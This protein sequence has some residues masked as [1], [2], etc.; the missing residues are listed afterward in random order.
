M[1]YLNS[2][3]WRYAAKRMNGGKLSQTQL[4]NILEATRLSASSFGLQPY[5]ILVIENPEVRAKLVPAAWNQP[6]LT[7]CSHLLVFC[8]WADVTEAQVTAY[9]EDTAQIRGID[10]AVL[11]DFKGMIL[12]ALANR[13]A[14]EKS[15][16]AA[17]QCYIA[18]G[19]TLIAAALENVDATPMEG[20]L[21][22]Q[23]DEILGLAAQG[24][25]SVLL[26][27]LGFRAAEGDYLAGAKKV[28]RA[29]SKLFKFI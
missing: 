29:K 18:L 1:S 4:D 19:S 11:N 20:F 10:V 28:R 22:A 3:N 27:P 5:T 14:A 25:R 15:E 21:P 13:T 17:K 26:C 12:G 2:L 8:A 7:E 9:M 24:L 16:W 6:Q 23:V